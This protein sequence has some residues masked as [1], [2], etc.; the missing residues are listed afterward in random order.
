MMKRFLS[1]AALSCTLP[2]HAVAQN[3]VPP[4][5]PPCR[6]EPQPDAPASAAL[7]P[8][9][10]TQPMPERGSVAPVN[11]LPSHVE[12]A[13]SRRMAAVNARQEAADVKKNPEPPCRPMATQIA[14]AEDGKKS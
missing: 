5:D 12:S 13:S 4:A 11:K 2:L 6:A 10:G 8:R 7:P 1:F 3:P 9:A 14:P